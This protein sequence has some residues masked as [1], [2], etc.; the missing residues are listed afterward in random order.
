MRVLGEFCITI[1][2]SNRRLELLRGEGVA[3]SGATSRRVMRSPS[4]RKNYGIM[5]GNLSGD[6]LEVTGVE[7]GLVASE[8]GLESGD[9]IIGMNGK[10]VASLSTDE[11]IACL[12][13]SPLLLQVERHN[14]YCQSSRDRGS[15]LAALVTRIS[16]PSS[17]KPRNP[18]RG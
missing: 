8:A 2:S 9:R 5:F 16:D 13:G 7:Q 17:Q 11:R 12:R 18:S 6:V 1:D 4:G 15:F 3:T 10:A 14:V